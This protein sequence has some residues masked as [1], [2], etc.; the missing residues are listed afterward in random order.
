MSTTDDLQAARQANYFD[1]QRDKPT[2]SRHKQSTDKEGKFQTITMK[3]PG[4]V[5]P[6]KQEDNGIYSTA[7]TKMNSKKPTKF[8]HKQTTNKQNVNA[9]QTFKT[10]TIKK[11]NKIL[12]QAV[13]EGRKPC[14]SLTKP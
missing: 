1:R 13:E 6:N 3:K 12:R 11:S 8:R 14:R 7:L 4:K 9:Q 5:T 10:Q 2:N